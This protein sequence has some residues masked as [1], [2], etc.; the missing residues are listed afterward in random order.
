MEIRY[1]KNLANCFKMI[2]LGRVDLVQT[3]KRNYDDAIKK[4][5][6]SSEKYSIFNFNNIT[7]VI[8]H[9]LKLTQI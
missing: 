2:N 1:L 9:I 7:S 5:I 8:L 6:F 3:S 4:N